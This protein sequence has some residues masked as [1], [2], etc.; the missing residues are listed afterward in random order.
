M[1]KMIEVKSSNIAKVGYDQT[2]KVLSIQFE[3]GKTYNYT[4]VPANVVLDLLFAESI[5]K[6]FN[7]EIKNKYLIK[8]EE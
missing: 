8:E 3:S 5:G 1:I 6:Y 7:T 4:A 2:K